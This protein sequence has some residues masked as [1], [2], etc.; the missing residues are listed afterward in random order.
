MFVYVKYVSRHDEYLDV[1]LF[2]GLQHPVTLTFN[3][4]LLQHKD[5][6]PL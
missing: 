3:D 6:K 4:S 1:K 2:D 5:F